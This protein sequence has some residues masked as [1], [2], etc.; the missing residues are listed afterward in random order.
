MSVFR[1]E[2]FL[3]FLFLFST[4]ACSIT[5]KKESPAPPPCIAGTGGF[6]QV[7]VF[8]NHGS[9]PMYNYL[10][11]P[12]TVF[13]KFNTLTSPGTSPS[14]YDT[15]FVSDFSMRNHIHCTGLKCGD[16][17]FYR[18][19]FDSIHNTRY[20]GGFALIVSPATHEIDTTVAV[21]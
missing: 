4:I 1:L 8:A 14:N 15:Y 6:V 16:Y 13:I 21:Y 3:F 9:T 12:D 19:A 7:V 5:C 20:Y 2:K 17:Y 11:H 10:S 18:T